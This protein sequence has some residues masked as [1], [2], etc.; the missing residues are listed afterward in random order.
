MDIKILDSHLREHLQ[1]DAKPKDIA[2]A[3]SLSSASIERVEELGKDFV[4]SVEITTN[5][6]D[7]VS[8]YGLAREAAAVLP[9]FGFDAKLIPLKLPVVVSETKDKQTV[10]IVNDDTLVRR[11]M[12]VILEITK[13][14]SPQ[15]IKDRLEAAGIRS[16][17]NLIDVTNY[18][19]LEIGHPTH[20]FDYDRLT[21]KQLI[22]RPSKKG[23]KVVTL[24]KKEHIL[25][26]GDIVADDGS[27][28]IVDL[29]GVM[30]TANSVVADTT[31][32]I[33]F[34]L[35]N[36][37]PWKIR[38]TSMGL[39]I[40]TE[41]AALNEKGIDPELAE[42]ALLRGVSLYK[43]MGAKV[44]S[45]VIDIYPG[46]I[47]PPTVTVTLEQ[48]NKTIGVEVS[49]LQAVKIL[50]DL[51]FGV[52]EKSGILTVKVPSWREGDVAIPEDIVEE[53]ARLYGYH[54]IPTALPPFTM[55]RYYHQKDNQ[56]FWE[57]KIK[58]ALKYWGLTE[59]YTY[60]FVSETL[61]EGP[62]DEA[63]TLANPL[64]SD[65]IH[66]RRTL[67]PSVLEVLAEN[68]SRENV[69][70]FELSNVYEKNKKEKLPTETRMLAF[71]LKGKLGNFS[72]AKGIVEGLLTELGI[73]HAIYTDSEMGGIGA[74]VLVQ[75]ENIGTIEVMDS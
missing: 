57:Q 72:H 28:T 74:T 55:Q 4:Y 58:D 6:P 56:F 61:F 26:G 48:I 47:K 51:G 34:F 75:K 65:H 1:T 33:L 46:K 16:L 31:K 24:D 43:D 45:D 66:M 9:F 68:K 8:V 41:A 2:K 53:V 54:N 27:G 69:G 29:L 15:F 5:R 38:K 50:T 52:T 10:K 25:Q 12:G 39:A 11:V 36:N 17:N 70:I 20:V 62:L 13:G 60:S 18:V 64:D 23:E 7:M 63:V 22:I 40:R 21:N 44:V 71:A 49:S 35:D 42:I 67:T 73:T 32:R 59:V 3:L 19:M 37:D 14:E 30:G